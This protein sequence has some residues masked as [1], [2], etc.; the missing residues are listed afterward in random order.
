MPEIVR[1]SVLCWSAKDFLIGYENNQFTLKITRNVSATNS[2]NLNAKVTVV[3][4]STQL[5]KTPFIVL[6]ETDLVDKQ[7]YGSGKT[8]KVGINYNPWVTDDGEAWKEML[9]IISEEA[10]R[11]LDLPTNIVSMV[12][13]QNDYPI[14]LQEP[15]KDSKQP[16]SFDD[17]LQTSGRIL[18]KMNLYVKTVEQTGASTLFI[19]YQIARNKY[20]PNEQ[21]AI[22]RTR[23]PKR[24]AENTKAG[25]E[26]KE[27]VKEEVA[28]EI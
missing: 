2:S 10:L 25:E 6:P 12:V 21:V 17:Y 24:K 22:P 14:F 16:F 13:P 8:E 5:E 9:S 15:W 27:E 3:M 1:S 19:G 20:N 26:S 7:T 23:K 18:F 28:V 11:V 4:N